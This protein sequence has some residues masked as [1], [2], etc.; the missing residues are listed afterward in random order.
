MTPQRPI[1]V[2]FVNENTLGHVSYL[3]R[4]VD[5]L[6]RRPELGIR[7]LPFDV[8][9]LP[10]ELA[11]RADLTIRGLRRFGL[12]FHVARWRKI[13]SA[14]AAEQLDA[15]RR[16][17]RL[18]AVVVN[19]QS[20]ALNLAAVA[21]KLPLFVCLDATFEQLQRSRWFA[22]NTLA[23][24]LTPFTLAP[25]LPLERDLFAT[26]AKLL[27]WS[28]PVRDSLVAEYRIAPERIAILPPSLDLSRFRRVP[29]P[30]HARP[31][32]LFLGGDFVRKG[33]PVLLEA[34]RRHLSHHCDLHI[35]TQSAVEPCPGVQI[36]RHISAGSPA[37]LERWNQADVFVF[38]SGLETFG[39]VLLEA[40]AFEV[41]VV[42]STA[43][44]AC[45]ILENGRTGVLLRDLS[46]SAIAEGIR[47]TLDQPEAARERA[48]L[49]RERVERDFELGRNTERLA[50][51]LRMAASPTP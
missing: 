49:G 44:A 39:I 28:A 18:H 8:T 25:I 45:D 34:Y 46:P 14:H 3:P 38:P 40:L 26:C 17:H 10:P 22:P 21:T 5:E 6:R 13:V 47:Q 43:G 9:P 41:P 42:A 32:V 2:A 51:M 12:D 7:P 30:P 19:T 33:G 31:Q 36:H 11:R 27:P 20:V 23:R 35:V 15:L 50:E 29:R 24:W 4:F 1:S 16:D 37:W 48:R